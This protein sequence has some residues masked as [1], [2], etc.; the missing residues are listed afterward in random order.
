M[1]LFMY[2]GKKMADYKFFSNADFAIIAFIGKLIFVRFISP[3]KILRPIYDITYEPTDLIHLIYLLSSN[4]LPPSFDA[5]S[6]LQ[7]SFYVIG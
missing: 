3:D 6:H 1:A 2:K 4:F 7:S 5:Y